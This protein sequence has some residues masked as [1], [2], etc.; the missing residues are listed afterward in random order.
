[1]LKNNINIILQKL[2]KYLN[3]PWVLFIIFSLIGAFIFFMR[4]PN[5]FYEPNFYAEDGSIFLLNIERYGFMGALLTT[6]NGYYVFG[7][8][9]LEGIGYVI[10]LL[11]F[12]HFIDLARS[13]A[14][15]SYL[16]LGAVCALPILL[17]KNKWGFL[18]TFLVFILS[19]FIPMPG[20]DYAIIG[21]IG[22]LKFI[23]VYL[24]F[25]LM[26]YRDRKSVV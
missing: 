21:T 22:N 7:M 18:T 24:A 15:T 13:F 16:F 19:V 12:G 17:F 5:N 6:F 26:I 20:Y 8:Y 23:F 1:M 4:F 11:T 10:N 9:L 25:L 3:K 2:S 14:I